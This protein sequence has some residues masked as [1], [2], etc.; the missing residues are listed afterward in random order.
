[1][2]VAACATPAFYMLEA[3]NPQLAHPQDWMIQGFQ[4]GAEGV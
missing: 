4:F 3:E 2:T 1:M